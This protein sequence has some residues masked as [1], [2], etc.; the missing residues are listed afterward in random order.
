MATGTYPG[1]F[2]TPGMGALVE[3]SEREIFW[4]GDD[5]QGARLYR[6]ANID[7]AARDAGNSPTTVLRPGLLLGKVTSTGFLKEWNPDASDG[8][9]YI[10]G[11]LRHELKATDFDANNAD[12]WATVVLRAPLITSRLL[13]EGTALTSSVD[14]YLARRQLD[15]LGCV[16]DDDPA[17]YQA[18]KGDRYETVTGTSDTITG[19]QNGMTL[20]YSSASA[21]AVTLPTIK[22]GLQFDFVRS[23]DEEL[24]VASAG[25]LDDIIC[26]GDAA[27]DSVTFTTAGQQ[28]GACLRVRAVYVATTLKWLA[29]VQVAP[30]STGALLASSFA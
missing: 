10:A 16:L 13:I 5:S 6:S 3:T 23:A 17:G 2:G 29:H 1:G 25:S 20:I 14:E 4:G 22:P 27:A 11:T 7:G 24:V 26:G 30:Y 21:V 28:I 8:T 19:D 12:R 18:G 9:Q 15:A